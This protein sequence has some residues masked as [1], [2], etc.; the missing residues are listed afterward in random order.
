MKDDPLPSGDHI[1]RYC[2]PTRVEDDQP[3]AAAFELAPKDNYLSVNWL[4]Y[5]GLPGKDD[6]IERIRE[7]FAREVKRDGRF[8]ALNVSEV[9]LA[10]EQL[11]RRPS[12]ITHQPTDDMESHAGLFGY[13]Q[14]EREVAAMLASIVTKDSM[15]PAVVTEG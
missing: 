1:A 2:S 8:A 7:E 4:E 15:F 11:T 3:L 5:W 13:S 14:N 9:K 10:V 6:A 12:D